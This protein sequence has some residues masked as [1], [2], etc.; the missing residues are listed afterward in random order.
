MGT[1]ASACRGRFFCFLGALP[2]FPVDMTVADS[3]SA[4][5]PSEGQQSS[6]RREN[7]S[8][9]AHANGAS[10]DANFGRGNYEGGEEA[11]L[12]EL[13]GRLRWS[14]RERQHLLRKVEWTERILLE[15][16]ED[17][18]ARRDAKET[19][20]LRQQLEERTAECSRWRDSFFDAMYYLAVVSPPLA[21]IADDDNFRRWKDSV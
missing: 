12:R 7:G 8:A 10:D 18:D 19:Q 20:R 5:S 15:V 16:R 3:G 13:S 14:E 21:E 6:V 1:D 9:P 11:N 17:R 2:P 4:A